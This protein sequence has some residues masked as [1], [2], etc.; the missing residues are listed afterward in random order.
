MN[1]KPSYQQEVIYCVLSSLQLG[2]RHAYLKNILC[3]YATA[4]LTKIKHY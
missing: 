4:V 3:F 1:K 2:T